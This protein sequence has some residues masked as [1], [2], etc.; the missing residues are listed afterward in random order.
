M[1]AS[2]IIAKAARVVP[3]QLDRGYKK[4][5]DLG[6]RLVKALFDW[7]ALVRVTKAP[8]LPDYGWNLLEI[9]GDM[10]DWMSDTIQPIP[11]LVVGELLL[12]GVTLDRWFRQ[13]VVTREGAV[14]LVWR[15]ALEQGVANFSDAIPPTWKYYQ[16][17]ERYMKLVDFLDKPGLKTLWKMIKKGPWKIAIT[18]LLWL[19]AFTKQLGVLIMLW[20]F[21][22][23]I[24]DEGSRTQVFRDSLKQTNGRK[25]ERVRIRRRVGG[26]PP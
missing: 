22:R 14:K 3:E 18:L 12:D 24:E 4:F 13:G 7:K 10:L 11:A 19:I 26:V 2:D 21:T 16:T 25:Y 20:N 15:V 6:D 1:K 9:L 8:P 23:M 5:G 17:M